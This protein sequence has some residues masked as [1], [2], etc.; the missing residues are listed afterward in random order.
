MVNIL[1]I[2]QPNVWVFH[3]D[4]AEV[5]RSCG[6][7]SF[8]MIIKCLKCFCDVVESAEFGFVSV[9]GQSQVLVALISV[10]VFSWLSLILGWRVRLSRWQ[11]RSQRGV[12]GS[13][14]LKISVRSVISTRV[15]IRASP[16]ADFTL[17][18]LDAQSKYQNDLSWKIIFKKNHI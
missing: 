3:L 8:A 16:L 11:M 17:S 5:Q 12:G 15:K 1:Y 10:R 7:S 4:E 18:T 9:T 6:I 14:S 2:V 13:C